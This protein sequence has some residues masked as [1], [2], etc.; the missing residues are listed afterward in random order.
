MF[1]QGSAHDL[2]YLPGFNLRRVL[3]EADVF[4]CPKLESARV[5]AKRQGW[6]L[7]GGRQEE[8]EEPIDLLS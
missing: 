4:S 1:S 5:V 6:T 8:E 3:R 2:V 7:R